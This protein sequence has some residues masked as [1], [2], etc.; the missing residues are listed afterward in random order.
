M[1]YKNS[2]DLSNP[3]CKVDNSHLDEAKQKKE[4]EDI[5]KHDGDQ[6]SK[7]ASNPEA[8]TKNLRL[9]RFKMGS[10]ASNTIF[11]RNSV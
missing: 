8:V 5:G 3:W 9:I 10:M 2:A 11:I 1:L 7:V 4:K 6:D